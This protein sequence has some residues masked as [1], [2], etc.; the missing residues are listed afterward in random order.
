ME[1]TLLFSVYKVLVQDMLSLTVFFFVKSNRG[2]A[3]L[4]VISTYMFR[5]CDK[6]GISN[7]FGEGSR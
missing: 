3:L 6:A 5:A 7:N 1:Y 2:L 4:S